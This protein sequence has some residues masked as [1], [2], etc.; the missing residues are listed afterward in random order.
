MTKSTESKPH[1][2]SVTAKI[3]NV[4]KYARAINKVCKAKMEKAREKH[5]ERTRRV[6][7]APSD[8]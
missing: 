2:V 3:L 5:S 1:K 8:P 7:R 4:A 6:S